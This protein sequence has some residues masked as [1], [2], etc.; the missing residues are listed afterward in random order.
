MEKIGRDFFQEINFITNLQVSE[1]GRIAFVK[2]KQDVKLNSY[3]S[4]IWTLEDGKER[5]LTCGKTE[6]SFIF[7]DA[8]HI[9]FVANRSE[10]KTVHTEYYRLDLKN[11]GEAQL[12]FSIPVAAGSIRDIGRYWLVSGQTDVNCPD[13]HLLDREHQM[14]YEKVKEENSDYQV[15]DEYPFMFN[16]A[17]F[18]NKTRNSLYLVDKKDFSVERIT[19][20]TM[21]VDS[22]DEKDG[23]IVYSGIDY[24]AV[25]WKWAQVY[26][27]NIETK[28]TECLYPEDDMLIMSVKYY[29]DRILVFGTFGREY[30]VTESAK[31][32]FLKDGQM[33]LFIDDDV[34]LWNS[35][36]SDAKWGRGR[37][38]DHFDGKMYIVPT[39]GPDANLHII[40]DGKMIPITHFSGC[41]CD[42]FVQKDQ[43]YVTAMVDQKLQEI[44]KVEQDGSLTQITWI[45]EELLKDKYVAKPQRVAVKKDGFEVEG[46]VL[47]PEGYTAEKQYPAILDIHGGPRSA[48]STIFFHEMQ[49]WAAE[50]FIVMYCN[51][52]GSDGYGNW[53][54]DI[55]KEKYGTIDY[56][57]LMDFTDEVI[58][59]YS[60]DEKRLAVTGGSYGGFMTNWIIGHTDRFCAAASQRSISNW[61]SMMTASDYGLDVPFEHGFDDVNNC[62]EQIWRVSPLKYAQNVKTPTLFIHSFEDYRCPYPEGMQMF[63][64]IRAVGVEARMCLFKG[65]NHELSRSGKPL[66]RSRRLEEITQWIKKYTD[67]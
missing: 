29:L 63:T 65:E 39:K 15:V 16:G 57:D 14:E 13:Y 3:V 31:L 35:I 7:E 61:M 55:R 43:I 60:V 58:R 18:I 17:G 2:T 48:Y 66:H 44:Y 27:Y 23:I 64:A 59:Q 8:D 12:A 33:Q 37:G 42:Y 47:V 20:V 62:T 40:R 5:Q 56:E 34:T 45:N 9:L 38:A 1:S 53:F 36:G 49:Y 6:R 22:F 30:G 52:R 4:H 26:Q 11:G 21:D 28:Q 54:A 41:V 25:K 24:T 32:F 10:D 46:W 67:R 51:P 50:G 19:S